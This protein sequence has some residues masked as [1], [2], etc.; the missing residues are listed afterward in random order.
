MV[1]RKLEEKSFQFKKEVGR[2]KKYF[3]VLSL[4]AMFVT[5]VCAEGDTI[6]YFSCKVKEPVKSKSNSKTKKPAKRTRTV[7]VKFAIENLDVYQDQGSLMQYP[8]S[9]EEDEEYGTI[10]VRPLESIM[11]NL[12]GQGG[13][14]RFEGRNIKLWGDGDGYQFTDLVIWDADEESEVVEGYV[15]DYGPAY[16]EYDRNEETFKQFIKCKRSSKVL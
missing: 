1:P 11:S 4:L 5:S 15:R 9:T 12:N 2:M 13:D 16:A 7:T 6:T 10:L 14:L 8:G 3:G